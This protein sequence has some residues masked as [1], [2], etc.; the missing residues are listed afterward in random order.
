[1]ILV[2]KLIV[3]LPLSCVITIYCL[4]KI[5]R[6]GFRLCTD[7]EKSFDTGHLLKILN[8]LAF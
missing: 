1:M 7:Q 4:L 6:Y 5:T 2:L 8:L 3:P